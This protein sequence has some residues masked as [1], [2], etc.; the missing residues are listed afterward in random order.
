MEVSTFVDLEVRDF[1]SLPLEM[2]RYCFGFLG[3]K[4]LCKLNLVCSRWLE[5]CASM[6]DYWE[7]LLKN[8][9]PKG[10]R[11]SSSD[12]FLHTGDLSWKSKYRLLTTSSL[13][14]V[15]FVFVGDCRVG[16]TKMIHKYLNF[17]FAN[18]LPTI[19]DTY[20]TRVSSGEAVHNVSVWDTSGD[21]EYDRL[22]PLS[23]MNADIAC[24]VFSYD[25]VHSF[26][27]ISTKWYP[28][29]RHFIPHASIVL[30]G[31][32]SSCARD[33]VDPQD[34]KSF[35]KH[36]KVSCYVECD[37]EYEMCLNLV[38]EEGLNAHAKKQAKKLQKRSLLS[39]FKRKA[40]PQLEPLLPSIKHLHYGVHNSHVGKNID[41]GSEEMWMLTQSPNR[42]TTVL[43]VAY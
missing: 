5:I 18:Y 33:G 22:R 4:E 30:I 24:I 31:V 21:E 35:I 40:K 13:K 32:K 43:Y 15:K 38:V 41:T 25:D 9:I 1:L 3:A 7:N 26:S 6:E 14:D 12:S 20:S 8:Y 23:Y 11:L 28:E 36:K 37:A 27:N 17:K 34:V 42:V 19:H 29:I 2:L 16:K 10:L 39:L